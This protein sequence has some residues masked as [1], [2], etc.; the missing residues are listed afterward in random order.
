M[1][2][3]AGGDPVA[4]GVLQRAMNRVVGGYAAE[5]AAGS[6]ASEK[7]DDGAGLVSVTGEHDLYTSSD[8]HDEIRRAVAE[9]PAVVVDLTG[10]TFIDSSVVGVLLDARNGAKA[11]EVGFAVCL[12]EGSADSVRRIFDITGLIDSLPV[13][14]GRDAAIS[15][16][17]SGQASKS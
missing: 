17:L 4:P 16:A 13:V 14:T 5:V 7:T 2:A 6:I 8:L 9:C 12:G 3:A 11:K 1:M 10:T 15:R